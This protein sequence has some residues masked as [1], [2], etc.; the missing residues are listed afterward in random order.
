MRGLGKDVAEEVRYS[1]G[2]DSSKMQQR[3]NSQGNGK[4]ITS[5]D[6]TFD[7]KSFVNGIIMSEILSKPKSKQNKEKS[8][9]DI[10]A[11]ST[12]WG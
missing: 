8:S 12:G 2:E 7:S 4:N 5:D 6:L 11:A 1:L 10:V 3:N 9:A